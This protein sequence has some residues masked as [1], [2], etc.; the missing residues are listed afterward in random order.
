MSRKLYN[1]LEIQVYSWQTIDTIST[2]EWNVGILGVRA[3]TT[4]FNCKKLL[5]THYFFPVKLFSVSLV[6]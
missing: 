4:H 2:E 6:P 1:F 5:Q 3:E